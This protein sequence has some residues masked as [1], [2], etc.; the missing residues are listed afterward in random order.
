[1]RLGMTKHNLET[2]QAEVHR[3]LL[4]CE[5]LLLFLIPFPTGHRLS[6][7]SC[8]WNNFSKVKKITTSF[9]CLKVFND[10]RADLLKYQHSPGDL[11]KM[12]LMHF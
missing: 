2:L 8:Y 4:C 7:L 6:P 5:V 1:M 12:Q 10:L 3:I 9:P 11:V